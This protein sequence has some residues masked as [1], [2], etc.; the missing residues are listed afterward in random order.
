MG[1]VRLTAKQ[2]GFAQDVAAGSSMVDAYTEHYDTKTDNMETIYPEASKVAANHKVSTRVKELTDKAIPDKDI[3]K[4]VVGTLV[5]V[6]ENSDNDGAVV[7]ASKHLGSAIGMFKE[8]T[9]AVESTMSIDDL[10]SSM[11]KGDQKIET[12]LREHFELPPVESD[13]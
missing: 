11:A 1:H 5:H 12:M 2:E 3:K 7:G 9:E 8:V 10:I 13:T 6:M 4:F